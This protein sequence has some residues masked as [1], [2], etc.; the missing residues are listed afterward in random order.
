[1]YRPVGDGPQF[2]PVPAAPPPPRGM[3]GPFFSSPP[4]LLP[5]GQTPA[6]GTPHGRPPLMQQQSSIPQQYAYPPPPPPPSGHQPPAAA[7][8]GQQMGPPL[9]LTPPISMRQPAPSMHQSMNAMHPPVSSFQ[10]SLPPQ[11][12]QSMPPSLPHP[13]TVLQQ[14]LPPPQA[15]FQSMQSSL[16]SMHPVPPPPPPFQSPPVQLQPPM[17]FTPAPLPSI[18]PNSFLPPL[19][20]SP[21]VENPPPPPPPSPPPRSP[22]LPHTEESL[23]MASL[24]PPEPLRPT[25]PEILKNIDVLAAFVVKNGPRFESMA[26]ARQAGD[27]KFA[28][29]FESDA[30]PEAAIGHEYYK[31]KKQCIELELGLSKN[32]KDDQADSGAVYGSSHARGISPFPDNTPASPAV[33]DMDMEDDFTPPPAKETVQQIPSDDMMTDKGRLALR[34]PSIQ[35]NTTHM[36]S[37]LQVNHGL[38]QETFMSS[39][40]MSKRHN[41]P[42][43]RKAIKEREYDR[44]NNIATLSNDNMDGIMQDELKFG[45]DRLLSKSHGVS[46][47]AKSFH[48]KMLDHDENQVHGTSAW[49]SQHVPY[50]VSNPISAKIHGDQTAEISSSSRYPLSVDRAITNG[51]A[52]TQSDKSAMTQFED[53]KNVP[54]DEDYGRLVRMEDL[55]NDSGDEMHSRKRRRNYS[56]SRSRSRSRSSSLSPNERGKRQGLSQSPSKRQRWSRSRSRSPQWQRIDDWSPSNKG[57]DV[58]GERD[59]KNE[60]ESIGRGRRVGRSSGPP[61]CF[62][63]TRGRCFRGDACKFLHPAVDQNSNMGQESGLQREAVQ[64]SDVKDNETLRNE[65]SGS[66]DVSMAPMGNGDHTVKEDAATQVVCSPH[67]Q[68]GRVEIEHDTGAKDASL[69]DSAPQNTERVEGSLPGE[70]QEEE[71]DEANT[72]DVNKKTNLSAE[73]RNSGNEQSVGEEENSIA[74]EEEGKNVRDKT[75]INVRSSEAIE[76]KVIKGSDKG[77]KEEFVS[78]HS[79]ELTHGTSGPVTEKD[80]VLNSRIGESE[81]LSEPETSDLEKLTPVDTVEIVGEKS[82]SSQVH[83]ALCAPQQSASSLPVRSLQGTLVTSPQYSGSP[84]RNGKLSIEQVAS[85]TKALDPGCYSSPRGSQIPAS[86]APNAKLQSPFPLNS[87]SLVQHMP[88]PS[89]PLESVHGTSLP[90]HRTSSDITQQQSF[91]RP[92]NHMMNF[93]MHQTIQPSRFPE[94]EQLDKKNFSAK[95]PWVSTKYTVPIGKS[96]YPQLSDNIPRQFSES[97]PSG[98]GLQHAFLRSNITTSTPVTHNTFPWN[99]GTSTA[100]RPISQNTQYSY[101]LTTIPPLPSMIKLP[102]SSN[103]SG[104]NDQYDPLSDGLDLGPS[105][106][107]KTSNM[108]AGEGRPT[109]SGFIRSLSPRYDAEKAADTDATNNNEGATDVGVVENVSPPGDWSPL[110]PEKETNAIHDH[111]KSK[112]SSRGLKLLRTAVADRVKVLLKPAWKE[113]RLSKDAFKTIAKKAVE[114]VTSNLPSHHIPKTQD[115]VDQFMAVSSPKISKLVQVYT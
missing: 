49:D 55:E 50:S 87:P 17:S 115:K 42:I 79:S 37:S 106:A 109:A 46:E 72:V 32:K 11:M 26:R 104:S 68:D 91:L 110:Q 62:H 103:I 53:Q 81:S 2:R 85:I 86:A 8:P 20:P 22:P 96:N 114:K 101:T 60:R 112:K 12:R 54:N 80:E 77:L 90:F 41:S 92:H 51:K 45:H 76:D 31:W 35:G 61:V 94:L 15:G 4:P 89:L 100:S 58:K 67:C 56:R 95:E 52:N 24:L 111:S 108:S 88:T 5:S 78:S 105:G 30:A 82:S 40:E 65:P 74:M 28:F 71:M 9:H 64:Q 38:D 44:N 33:S 73:L 59:G 29:L 113:G 63:Y 75:H 10:R 14:P 13:Q 16:P 39:P 69:H 47:R 25:D 21:P 34:Y 84:N 48:G 70:T 98:D 18:Q 43:V 3:G 57:E 23:S 97:V 107:F 83:S 36:D 66:T 99:G 6:M 19:P 102:G 93:E 27:P 1:M 7:V